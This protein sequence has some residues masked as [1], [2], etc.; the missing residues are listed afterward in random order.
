MKKIEDQAI[1]A[2][3]RVYS[4][5]IRRQSTLL[6]GPN[7]TMQRPCTSWRRH[8]RTYLQTTTTATTLTT[9]RVGGS[10]GD[11]LN[12]T[13]S[14]AGTGKST[15]GGLSTGTGGL[16]AVT[17]GSTDLDVEGVDAELLA[18]SGN[19]LGSQ[20]GSIGGR[21]ITVSLDLHTTGDTADGFATTVIQ[22]L[23]RRLF[24]TLYPLSARSISKG[25]THMNGEIV[26]NLMR[27]TSDR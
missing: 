5:H 24:A 12:A 2:V 27:R 18:A 11:V 21:L 3:L 10:G 16:G 9:G 23:A 26:G 15:E 1:K 20:H 22:Q 8:T 7:P 25:E 6:I 14:H 13:D 4:I 19:I 17:T